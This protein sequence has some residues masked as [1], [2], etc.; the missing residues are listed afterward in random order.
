MSAK[1]DAA[2]PPAD[3]YNAASYAPGE[4]LGWLVKRV[5]QSIVHQA[6]KRL[7]EHGLTHAQWGP[8]I[9]LF[10]LGAC[11]AAQLAADLGLDAGALTRL[12]DR[13]EA[14]GL[15][16]RDRSS[17]D[18][19]VVLITLTDAGRGLTDILPAVLS[20]IFNA[21]LAG[22][23]REEWQTL[24]SLLRRMLANGEAL[25]AAEN[26]SSNNND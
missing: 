5:Q 14:K 13:L 19:R 20:D 4:S 3:F 6:D 8:L 2:P 18:R 24:M 9:R 1:Q 25:R 17:S 16:Q 11:P 22:F 7:G 15:V 12:L 26:S 23:S 10:F 21:H